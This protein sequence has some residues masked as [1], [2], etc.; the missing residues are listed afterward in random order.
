[1]IKYLKNPFVLIGSGVVLLL[2]VVLGIGG[3]FMEGENVLKVAPTMWYLNDS[4][5]EV[6]SIA[7]EEGRYLSFS[8][9]KEKILLGYLDRLP[10]VKRGQWTL[11]EQ[12]GQSLLYK[13]MDKDTQKVKQ[14]VK[15]NYTNFMDKYIIFTYQIK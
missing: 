8:A 11:E 13:N 1:M 10:D 15:I 2:L 3:L 6:L 5:R 7:G 4:D 12:Q 14:Q 9:D